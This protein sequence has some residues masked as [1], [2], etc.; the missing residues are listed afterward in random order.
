MGIF[1][2]FNP[3][4][5]E[6]KIGTEESSAAFTKMVDS[7]TQASGVTAIQMSQWLI[8]VAYITHNFKLACCYLNF[9]V[10]FV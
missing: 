10:H 4:S 7:S 2:V 6:Y 9:Y 5:Y 3:P 8:I 1:Y